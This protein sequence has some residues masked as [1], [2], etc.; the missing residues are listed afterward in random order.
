MM[1]TATDRRLFSELPFNDGR[2]YTSGNVDRRKYDRLVNLGWVKA[3]STNISDVEYHLT[4]A[5]RLELELIKEAAAMDG[6]FPDPAP[7][8]FQTEVNAGPRRHAGIKLRVGARV[9]LGHNAFIVDAIDGEVVTVTID[10]NMHTL[11]V[12]P[13]LIGQS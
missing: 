9:Q 12:P 2:L 4:L 8:G 7:T 13:N 6:D 3:V 10:G 5:G 11:N 1:P